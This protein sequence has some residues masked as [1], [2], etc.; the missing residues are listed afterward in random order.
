MCS[1]PKRLAFAAIHRS[2]RL[3]DALEHCRYRAGRRD[4]YEDYPASADDEENEEDQDEVDWLSYV[5]PERAH[6]TLDIADGVYAEP[7]MLGP[8]ELDHPRRRG[9]HP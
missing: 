3:A 2:Q 8:R 5:D 9:R 7:R 6:F 1:Y 4:G